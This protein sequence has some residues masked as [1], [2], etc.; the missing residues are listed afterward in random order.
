MRPGANHGISSSKRCA[1][2]ALAV[3]TASSRPLLCVASSASANASA[4]PANSGKSI[5]APGLGRAGRE[6]REREADTM[7]RVRL[8]GVGL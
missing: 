2:A 6:S 7:R 1:S 3:T 5:R 8:G 4:E